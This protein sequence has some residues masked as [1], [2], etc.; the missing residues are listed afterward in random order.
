M[1]TILT[2][3]VK[4]NS[5]TKRYKCPYCDKHDTRDKLVSHIDKEH[6]DMIPQNYTASRVLFNYINKKE[7]GTCVCGCGRK[8]VWNEDLGRYERL[9]RDPK[10]K[11]RYI[12]IVNTRK[13]NK[14]GTWNLAADP[15]FQEKMLAGRRISG[16]YKIEGESFTY[17]GQYEKNMLEFLDKVMHYGR[18]D[19][20]C[21]GPIIPYKYKGETLYYISDMMIIPYNLIIEIKDGGDNP[22]NR[23]MDEYRAKQLAKEA[24]IKEDGEYNYVRVTNNQFDQLLAVLAELKMQYLDSN[25][26][27]EKIFRVNES[28]EPITNIPNK[29]VLVHYQNQITLEQGLFA[30]KD[31]LLQEVYT[32]IGVFPG[33]EVLK[34]CNYNMY[35]PKNSVDKS[36]F[37]NGNIDTSSIY[38]AFTGNRLYSYGQIS[39]DP[40]LEKATDV[41]GAIEESADDT[42]SYMLGGEKETMKK[43]NKLEE[44]L[45]EIGGNL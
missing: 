32:D 17:T 8:T 6:S 19:I 40:N 27:T 18:T 9:T 43:L 25:S 16:T 20:M 11:E 10:C 37:E 14:F 44:Q 31:V 45:Q 12:E 26:N 15:K 24:Q 28:L 29:P 2:E 7:Y 1:C 41:W 3:A 38:E 42:V 13:I 39:L 33:S 23:P 35:I 4:K 21:P 34:N 22:N 30:A 36:I 5:S